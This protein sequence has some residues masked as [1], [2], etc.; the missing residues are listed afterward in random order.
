MEI[1]GPVHEC[2]GASD[3]KDDDIHVVNRNRFQ[4][5]GFSA[6]PPVGTYVGLSFWAC[7]SLI[8]SSGVLCSKAYH[9]IERQRSI[10]VNFEVR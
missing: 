6:H 4:D 8:D 10:K 3:C 1:D 5:H 7:W 2:V 9:R